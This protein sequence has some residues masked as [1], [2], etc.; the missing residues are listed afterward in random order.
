MVKNF[1]QG[2]HVFAGNTIAPRHHTLAVLTEEITRNGDNALFMFFNH[3]QRNRGN[4]CP[5]VTVFV[6]VTD[7]AEQ[8]VIPRLV[9]D[10]ESQPFKCGRIFLVGARSVY[11]NMA[12]INGLYRREALLFTGLVH[13][14]SA[15]LNF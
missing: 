1:V 10:Q 11:I 13:V 9:F 2:F 5:T 12:T 14:L 3:R 6:T 7:N 8:V 4:F 15:S